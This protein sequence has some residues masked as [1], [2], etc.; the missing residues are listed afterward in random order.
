[1]I[2]RFSSLPPLRHWAPLLAVFALLAA[3]S[4]DKSSEQSSSSSPPPQDSSKT[5]PAS[6]AATDPSTARYFTN[7]KAVAP[8][9]VERPTPKGDLTFTLDVADVKD[10]VVRVRG[11]GFRLA[12][13]H[14]KGDRVT[15]LLVGPSTYSA[16]ADVELRPDVSNVLKTP[17]LDDTG[18]V[19]LIN[20]STVPPGEYTIFLQIGGA[21]GEAIKSTN[22]NLTL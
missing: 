4:D 9:S 17:G 21:D 2:R 1:M 6:N 19:G 22:R 12:P 8:A 13:P 18:F 5:A 3:C 20:A 7:S 10:K 14:Q 11:W 15:V 16:M